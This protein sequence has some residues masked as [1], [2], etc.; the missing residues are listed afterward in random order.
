LIA[1]GKRHRLPKNAIRAGDPLTAEVTVTNTGQREGDEVAQMYLSFPRVAGA[2]LRAL[3]G[4]ILTMLITG[5][6][7]VVVYFGGISLLKVE[8]MRLLKQ[9]VLARLGRR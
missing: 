2:P 3:R 8:E 9:A 6:A 7:A 1:V 4:Q 5:G